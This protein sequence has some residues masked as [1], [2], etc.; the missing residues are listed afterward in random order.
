MK[1]FEQVLQSALD[2]PE[3]FL[4]RV[5]TRPDADS[6]VLSLR[7]VADGW[8]EAEDVDERGRM[9]WYRLDAFFSVEIEE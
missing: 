1:T 4:L 3:G 6:L 9:V 2:T 7:S 5:R 8:I